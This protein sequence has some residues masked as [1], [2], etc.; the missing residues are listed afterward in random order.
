MNEH[1]FP[2]VFVILGFISILGEELGWRGFLQDALRPLPEFL[3]YV[4]IGIMW[5]LW[6]FTNRMGHGELLQV[7]IRVSI[8]IAALILISFIMGRATDRSKSVVVAVTLH[9]WIDILAEF[10]QAAT[11]IVF[12]LAIPF[13]IYLLW[14]WSDKNNLQQQV[15]LQE[16]GTELQF[17]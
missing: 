7:V 6:H 3:W 2:L 13:W 5:E 11:Y 4:L 15:T 16:K 14:K 8:W 10:S 1:L 17:D 9:A 12:G